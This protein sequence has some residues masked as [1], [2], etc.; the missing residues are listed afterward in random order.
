MAD[1]VCDAWLNLQCGLS[2]IKEGRACIFSALD[3][4]QVGHAGS[5]C[6]RPCLTHQCLV[7]QV[8]DIGSNALCKPAELRELGTLR[9]V[10]DLVLA[11]NPWCEV[12]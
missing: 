8:L 2:S 11:G 5:A 9:R 12:E 3:Q 1:A 10:T 7:N 4:L 6:D